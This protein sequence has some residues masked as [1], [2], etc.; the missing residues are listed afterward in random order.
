VIY[1]SGADPFRDDRFGRLSLDF[2]DLRA[3]DEMV[4]DACR[5][6]GLPVAVSMAGGYARKVDDTVAIHLATI[7]AGMRCAGLRRN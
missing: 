3:R 6:R 7:G 1:V 4:F 2:A 5:R